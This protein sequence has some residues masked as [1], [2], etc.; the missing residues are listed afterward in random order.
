MF[1]VMVMVISKVIVMA[2]TQRKVAMPSLKKFTVENSGSRSVKSAFVFSG[3]HDKTS[4]FSFAADL[5]CSIVYS[6]PDK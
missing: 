5:I 3:N 1:K 4:Q 6:N 2:M